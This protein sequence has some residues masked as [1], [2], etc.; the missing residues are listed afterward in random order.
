[1]THPQASPSLSMLAGL[2]L[3]S[4]DGKRLYAAETGDNKV[5]EIDL[6]SGTVLRR[7]PAGKQGDGLAI[8]GE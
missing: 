2:P 8:A 3:R 6:A 4:A 5:A 1:M 7:L